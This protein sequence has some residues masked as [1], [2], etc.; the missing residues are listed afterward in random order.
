MIFLLCGGGGVHLWVTL[1]RN[2]NGRQSPT[3]SKRTAKPL[4]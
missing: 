3:L 2:L 4:K 1:L